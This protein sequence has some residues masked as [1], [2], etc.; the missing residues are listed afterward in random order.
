M[1]EIFE[2][3]KVPFGNIASKDI[4]SIIQ[5][6]DTPHPK[7]KCC[8]EELYAL[9]KKCWNPDKSKRPDFSEITEKIVQLIEELTDYSNVFQEDETISLNPSYEEK[10]VQSLYTNTDS[11]RFK[12]ANEKQTEYDFTEV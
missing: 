11:V 8:P 3:G 2:F 10:S 1:W 9:L 12:S 4:L 5:Y 6:S 7:P